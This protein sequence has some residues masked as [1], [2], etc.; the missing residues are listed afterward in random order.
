MKTLVI[1]DPSKLWFTSDTHF[2]HEN[3]I[4]YCN[5]PFHDV[6]H[7]DRTIINNWNSII[8]KD[9]I[10]IHAG[11]FC[12]GNRDMWCYFLSQ[13]RGNKILIQGNHDK[14]KNIPTD[15]FLNVYWG[16]INLEVKDV[17]SEG[18]SQRIT[19]CH[20]PM[21]SWYQSHRGAWQLF[22]H[23][24][25]TTIVP[26][27]DNEGEIID[28]NILEGNKEVKEYVKEEYLHMDKIRPGQYDIGVDGNNFTPV[29]Y[30]EIK[31]IINGK[32]K[33]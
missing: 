16:F 3:I 21:L 25:N 30:Y 23:W 11:D 4:R 27:I 17:E 31:K 29:S 10:V 32:V 2:H 19:V 28:E 6:G 12:W 15:K 7:M 24:H 20:Y 8:E 1:K 5:R 18:G 9:D 26:P 22:G 13:L 14:D 33:E